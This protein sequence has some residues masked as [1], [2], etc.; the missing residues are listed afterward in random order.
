MTH[1]VVHFE[2]SGPDDRQ[3]AGFYADLFGW[4]V[5]PAP[6]V[7]YTLIDTGGGINGGVARA[8]DS[9]AA[10]TF[11]IETDDLQTALDKI[12]LVGG[13]TVRPIT[14]LPGMATYALFEDLDGLVVGLVLG[15]GESGMP[16]AAQAETPVADQSGGPV[17]DWFEILGTDAARSQRFYTEIFGWHISPPAGAG[18]GTIDT[19]T[20]RGIRGGIGGCGADRPGPWVTV[21]ASVPDVAA[22]LAAAARLGGGAVLGPVAVDDQLETG[23]LRDPVGNVLGVYHGPH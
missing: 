18:Y 17:V 20:S 3:L 8:A 11:Y 9:P 13:K 1:P 21:Y 16:T 15:A 7:G 10:A 23:A 4:R 2:L 19:G 12:N 14:E 22:T 5:R 6:G